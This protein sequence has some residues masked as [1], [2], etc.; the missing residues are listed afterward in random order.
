MLTEAQ[1]R[2][3]Q[4]I[5]EQH[6]ERQIGELM[7]VAQQVWDSTHDNRGSWEQLTDEMREVYSEAMRKAT[8]REL[9]KY[10]RPL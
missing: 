1:R 4:E 2:T 10:R 8:D 9:K 6:I 3:L 5:A 7:T